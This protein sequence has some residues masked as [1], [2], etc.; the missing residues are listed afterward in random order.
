MTTPA[1]LLNTDSPP[2]ERMHL[3][4][5]EAQNEYIERAVYWYLEALDQHERGEDID[6]YLHILGWEQNHGHFGKHQ[7]TLKDHEIDFIL[8]GRGTENPNFHGRLAFVACDRSFDSTADNPAYK[9]AYEAH[10]NEEPLDEPTTAFREILKIINSD[11]G[12]T[13]RLM[14]ADKITSDLDEMFEPDGKKHD[15]LDELHVEMIDLCLQLNEP[16]LASYFVDQIDD[17]GLRVGLYFRSVKTL[18]AAAFAVLERL[19]DMRQALQDNPQMLSEFLIREISIFGDK[20]ANLETNVDEVLTMASDPAIFSQ[21]ESNLDNNSFVVGLPD[22]IART[23][24][25]GR[26]ASA[27]SI[28]L[29]LAKALMNVRPDLAE[30]VIQTIPVE[31]GRYHKDFQDSKIFHLAY[32]GQLTR[33]QRR[34]LKRKI[35]KSRDTVEKE[36]YQRDLDLDQQKKDEAK[37]GVEADRQPYDGPRMSD[38]KMFSGRGNMLMRFYEAI[39]LDSHEQSERIFQEVLASPSRSKVEKSLAA[40]AMAGTFERTSEQQDQLVSQVNSD[41]DVL[42]KSLPIM[43]NT[44]ADIVDRSE[45]RQGVNADTTPVFK[46]IGRV[47]DPV[48]RLELLTRFAEIQAVQDTSAGSVWNDL[49]TQVQQTYAQIV[50]SGEHVDAESSVARLSGIGIE[51]KSVGV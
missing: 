51:I 18:N 2:P 49:R 48:R 46:E 44:Y 30:S 12:H 26:L 32:N 23:L 24:K 38:L 3:A 1:E 25:N 41:L 21:T 10:Q 36:H 19:G 34:A 22:R 39:S 33:K 17:L 4:N 5:L 14:Y 20:V 35:R 40:L 16:V 50:N 6:E 43:G 27:N 47:I 8:E 45:H 31:A 42:A 7:R 37:G 28:R 15:Q 29:K 11:S 9:R 13:D